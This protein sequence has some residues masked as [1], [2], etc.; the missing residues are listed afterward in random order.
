MTAEPLDV[1]V[2]IDDVLFPLATRLHSKAHELGLHDNT[3]EALEVWHGWKQYGCRPEQWLEVFGQLADE[4]YYVDAEP[5][6]GSV[7]ALRRLYWEG[8]RIHL[9]TARGFPFTDDVRDYSNKI[10][11]WTVQWVEENAIPHYGVVTFS[12]DK[13]GVALRMTASGQWDYALDD[14]D[15]NYLALD[16]AGIPVYLLDQPHN[17]AFAAER[18]V[19]TVDEFVDIILEETA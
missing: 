19:N 4:G 6:P 10:R 8:H 14:G 9:V 17:R 18:R 7:E 11:E 12:K 2:D 5:I 15:H 16:N 3:R 1:M 13:V